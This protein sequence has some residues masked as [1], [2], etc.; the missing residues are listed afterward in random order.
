MNDDFFVGGARTGRLGRVDDRIV[1][2]LGAIDQGTPAD[3]AL[4][5]VFK[6]ARDLGS[7]ERHEVSETVY[8]VVRA[9]RRIDD[10]LQRAAKASRR[11][12]DLLEGPILTRLRVLAWLAEQGMGLDGLKS[13]DPYAFKRV[14]GLFERITRGRLPEPK[15]RRP[16]VALAVRVSLPDWMASR[17]MNAYGLERAEAIG[18]AL[19]LRAPLTLR[20]NRL[21]ADRDEVLEALP[22][23][24]PTAYSPDGIT[25]QGTA[26]VS[27]WPLYKE[28]KVEIQDEASQLATLA[29]G[30]TRG[31]TILD[32]CAGA[33]GKTLALGAA[34]EGSGRPT[35]PTSAR[36]PPP[37]TPT[38][39]TWR[40]WPRPRRRPDLSPLTPGAALENRSGSGATPGALLHCRR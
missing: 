28:G 18:Q 19:S 20:V 10:T 35:T 26:D 38:A 2:V 24:S 27:S 11:R 22:T 4:G 15:K 36:V 5:R 29:L 13:R 30:A 34:M 21:L 40:C 17:L 25:L 1:D 9:R 32:A 8:G 37:P 3:R 16:E 7:R 23:A 33:G 6:N 12:L 14:S 39:S 31:E